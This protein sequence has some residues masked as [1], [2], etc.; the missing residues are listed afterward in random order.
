MALIFSGYI[1]YDWARANAILKTLDNAI[2]SAAALYL[3]ISTC[4]TYFT[5][6]QPSL[7]FR[8]FTTGFYTYRSLWLPFLRSLALFS[9]YSVQQRIQAVLSELNRVILGK[10]EEIQLAVCCLLAKGHLLIEDLRRA[11]VKTTLAHALATVMGIDYQR[12]IYFRTC[13]LPIARCLSV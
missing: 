12:V 4:S 11:W 7:I 2:D 6:S 13:C 8:P 3:D 9:E 1:G 5:H 10:E